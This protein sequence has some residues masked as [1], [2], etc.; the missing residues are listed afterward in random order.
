MEKLN[1]YNT[2]DPEISRVALNKFKNHLWYLNPE[3]IVLA[4][5]DNNVPFECKRKMVEAYIMIKSKITNVFGE[6]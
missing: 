4:F 1:D 2:I 5:Y 3:A 6:S